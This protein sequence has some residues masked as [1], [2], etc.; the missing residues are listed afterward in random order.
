MEFNEYVEEDNDLSEDKELEEQDDDDDDYSSKDEFG[1]GNHVHDNAP[2][3]LDLANGFFP[4]RAVIHPCSM[5]G[6]VLLRRV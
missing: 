1:L 2:P 6:T 3:G 5:S 4:P